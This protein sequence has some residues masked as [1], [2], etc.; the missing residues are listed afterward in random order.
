M[1][2]KGITTDDAVTKKV[3]DESAFR[4]ARKEMYVSKFMGKDSS[5][6]IY[7]K[8]QLEKDMGDNITFTMF[9]RAQAPVI[10]GSS[11]EAVEGKEGKFEQ[12]T[13]SITLE[14]YNTAFRT[15]NK[16]TIDA[17]RPW[18]NLTDENAKALEQ[19]SSEVMDELWFKAIQANPTRIVYG[20]DATS[21]ATL[22]AGDKLNPTLIRRLRAMAK[23]GFATGSN[24]RKAYPFK[25]VKIGGVD[26]YVLLVHPYAVYDM[27]E[28]AAYQ[29]SVREA[30]ERSKNNPIFTG[31]VAVID[32]V[33]IHEH[34]N[35]QIKQTTSSS[36]IYYCTGV[37]MGAG[38][39]I[40]AWG[41]RWSTYT[42]YFD[43]GRE[44]GV[45]RSM[46]AAT[47]K[48][49]FK[50]TSTGSAADYGSCGVYIACTDVVNVA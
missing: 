28:N 45:N 47:K 3:W 11:G 50:F 34:E 15:K 46:I 6:M 14:E 31:A 33:I 23:T 35:I 9:P 5:A 30:M 44:I 12:F 4:E 16:G 10:L 42:E 40:W 18:F 20:G 26:Y 13:D 39:S 32:N 38:S 36:G 7:E 25:S 17:Q 48:T 1:A 2:V 41:K 21:V 19:W 43:F 37:F 27:K 29:Q 8:T 49:S 24:A 22:E